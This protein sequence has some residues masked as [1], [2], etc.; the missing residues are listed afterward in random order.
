V[1]SG[2][3]LVNATA[4][5]ASIAFISSGL[6]KISRRNQLVEA[7]GHAARSITEL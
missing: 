2:G 4:G 5:R 3:A 6:I 1:A 7:I